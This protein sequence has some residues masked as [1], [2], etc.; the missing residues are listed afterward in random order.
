[1]SSPLLDIYSRIYRE[2]TNFIM[3]LSAFHGIHVAVYLAAVSTLARRTSNGYFLLIITTLLF[4]VSTVWFMV[5][6]HL[7]IAVALAAFRPDVYDILRH[8]AAPL[9]VIVRIN[10]VLSD[11]VVVWRAWILWPRSRRVRVV[12]IGAIVC[13]AAGSIAELAYSYTKFGWMAYAAN[14][15]KQ[16]ANYSRA[17]L[18]ILPVILTN[19]LSTALVGYKVWEYR[20]NVKSSL[21]GV[22]QTRVEKILLLLVESG[23]IYSAIWVIYLA[24]VLADINGAFDSDLTHMGPAAMMVP[25]M[26]A[27]AAVVEDDCAR[28]KP[29]QHAFLLFLLTS[30]SK[31]TGLIFVNRALDLVGLSLLL[32]DYTITIGEYIFSVHLPIDHLRL[33]QIQVWAVANQDGDFDVRKAKNG[34]GMSCLVL[35]VPDSS[36][37]WMSAVWIILMVFDLI[38]FVLTAFK[39]M[40]AVREPK[41]AL[42]RVLLRD[43]CL[44]FGFMVLLNAANVVTY[45]PYLRGCL[46]TLANR[47]PPEMATG[48]EAQMKLAALAVQSVLFGIYIALVLAMIYLLTLRPHSETVRRT[49]RLGERLLFAGLI[50]LSAMITGEWICIVIR[51]F[52]AFILWEGGQHADNFYANITGPSEVL[53]SAFHSATVTIADLFVV[54]RLYVIWN[55]RKSVILLPITALV[56]LLGTES[57]I[58]AVGVT[59]AYGAYEMMDPATLASLHRWRMA[60]SILTIWYALLDSAARPRFDEAAHSINVYCTVG[61]VQR[62]AAQFSGSRSVRSVVTLMAESAAFYTSIVLIAQI[63]YGTNHVSNY[64]FNDCI[65]PAAALAAV[66]VH[67]RAVLGRGGGQEGDA[68]MGPVEGRRG[69]RGSSRGRRG[70]SWGGGDGRA[71]TWG[72]RAST[73]DGRAEACGGRDLAWAGR[74]ERSP[75]TPTFGD[76][77]NGEERRSASTEGRRSS[78]T[79]GRRSTVKRCSPIQIHVTQSSQSCVDLRD[80]PKAVCR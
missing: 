5:N 79:E 72:G 12:L 13:T 80:V 9:L 4:V 76:R 19:I 41:M 45:Y 77:A 59:Y 36:V 73:W 34:S 1:M 70:S 49:S 10:H 46:G 63:T 47:T 21:G 52:Q 44:Y 29:G 71:E 39:T 51:A 60:Q 11:V 7:E 55:Y 62:Q 32:Y 30:V 64:F 28:F 40:E 61:R 57:T 75:S 2:H 14:L 74:V 31:P 42:S 26:P 20:R 25:V 8:V 23:V 78:S 66:L 69:S 16:S 17:F 58:S 37:H 38:V 35:Y 27:I 48:L 24:V 3:M 18:T 33:I 50:L 68:E 6:F 15:P 53:R 43:A 67:V 54:A 56:L 65:P 22:A